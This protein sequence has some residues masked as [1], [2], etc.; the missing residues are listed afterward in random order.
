M[1]LKHPTSPSKLVGRIAV[2]GMALA[3][4]ALGALAI[5]AAIVTQNGADGLTEAGVQTSGH[6]RA[7]QALTIIDTS[8]DELEQGI[9]PS[10]LAKLRKGQR[11]LDDSLRR[12]DSGDV[13]ETR[14]MVAR[15]KPIMRVMKPRIERFLARPPGYDS[16]GTAGREQAMEASISELQLLLNDLDSDPSGLL[17]E[18][19]AAV[20]ASERAVRRTAF[21]LIPLGLASVMVCAWLLSSYRRRS[22][23]MMRGALDVTAQEARTDQLTG[24]PNR[25]ALL[26][27]FERRS[28]G[29]ESFTLTLADLNGFKRYNDTFGHPAGDALLRRLGHKLAAASEGRGIAARLGG[30][31]FCVMLL[32]THARGRSARPD[33]GGA[34]RRGRGLPHHR[35]VGRRGG[36]RGRR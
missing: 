16:D 4:A 1:P 8:S 21:V 19:L 6:L 34:Q 18:K 10:E 12:M 30:D 13:H 36:A 9:V 33:R 20:T 2:A 28:A 17:T 22:E 29:N 23:A 14:R 15:A 27:E 11:I 3:V 35:R 26:E 7:I 32:R 24:L 25:R 31:E 5:W